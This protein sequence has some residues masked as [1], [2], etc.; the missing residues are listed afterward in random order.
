M[1]ERVPSINLQRPKSRSRDTCRW[2]LLS[3]SSREAKLSGREPPVERGRIS[4]PSEVE[5]LNPCVGFC[6][7]TAES[8]RSGDS[9]RN[10]VSLRPVFAPFMTFTSPSS[11]GVSSAALGKA[12]SGDLYGEWPTNASV[13][14]DG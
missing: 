8:V 4:F 1:P 7:H 3:S 5:T 14:A 12:R 9:G 13:W 10:D 2:N 11:A 6:R